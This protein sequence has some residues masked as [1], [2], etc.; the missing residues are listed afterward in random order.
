MFVALVDH[1]RSLVSHHELVS[2]ANVCCVFNRSATTVVVLISGAL[3]R[4]RLI[5]KSVCTSVSE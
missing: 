5:T 2:C 3:V 4:G 1:I